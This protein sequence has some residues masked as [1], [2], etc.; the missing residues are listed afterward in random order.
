MKSHLSPARQQLLEIIHSLGFGVIE[1]L[2]IADGEPCFDPSPKILQ[3]IKIGVVDPGPR[4]EETHRDFT[5]K[6][7][8][9]ELFEHFD[10][11]NCSKVNIEVKHAQPFRIVAEYDPGATGVQV[12]HVS[13]R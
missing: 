8:M 4:P 12:Q 10:R 11:L 2:V 6:S 7:R 3:D 1:G 13:P 9:V 5:L